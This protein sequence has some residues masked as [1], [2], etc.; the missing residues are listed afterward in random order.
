M[1][2]AVDEEKKYFSALIGLTSLPRPSDKSAQFS[3]ELLLYYMQRE[4]FLCRVIAVI[5]YF[6]VCEKY[7]KTKKREKSK[8]HTSRS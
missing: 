3:I 7:F 5:Y 1:I 4:P 8:I 6:Y 2:Y